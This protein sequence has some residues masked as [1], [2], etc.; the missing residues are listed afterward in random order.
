MPKCGNDVNDGKYTR[1]R[2]MAKGPRFQS[3][4]TLGKTVKL[5]SDGNSP[6]PFTRKFFSFISPTKASESHQ[7]RVSEYVCRNFWFDVVSLN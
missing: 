7:S 1:Q 5:N 6:G 3:G 2:F 4:K